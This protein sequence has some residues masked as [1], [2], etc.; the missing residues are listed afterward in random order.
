MPS[1]YLDGA[2]RRGVVARFHAG[3][4]PSRAF[5]VQHLHPG[6]PNLVRWPSR[7]P[8]VATLGVPAPNEASVPAGDQLPVTR[9]FRRSFH[10]SIPQLF[11]RSP[12][13][14]P[15]RTSSRR[16]RSVRETLG[17][18]HSLAQRRTSM[19]RAMPDGP[20]W[21]ARLRHASEPRPMK[22]APGK[23][24][25]KRSVFGLPPCCR[26]FRPTASRRSFLVAS[27]CFSRCF[28]P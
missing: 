25:S 3:F 26:G 10:S 21:I 27:R 17:P 9:S 23:A 18:F 7:S 19:F 12:G 15:R 1:R 2:E 8:L 5:P 4:Q 28:L 6:L 22:Q 24:P 14:I 16:R 13:Q 20:D 11:Q